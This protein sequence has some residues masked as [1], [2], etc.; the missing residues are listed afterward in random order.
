MLV[1]CV[2]WILLMNVGKFHIDPSCGAE[3]AFANW[4]GIKC[5]LWMYGVRVSLSRASPSLASLSA[6]S[7][8]VIQ[9]CAHTF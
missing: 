2:L 9:V 8:L 1:S 3:S 7:L 5:A 4:F 6:I